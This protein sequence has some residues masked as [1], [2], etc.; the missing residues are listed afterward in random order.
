MADW[1]GHIIHPISLWQVSKAKSSMVKEA[2]ALRTY[3]MEFI[4]LSNKSF[5]NSIKNLVPMYANNNVI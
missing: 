2:F 1:P 4:V 3:I 5:A